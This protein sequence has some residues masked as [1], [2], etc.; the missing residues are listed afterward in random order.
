MFL[1]GIVSY[2]V[3]LCTKLVILKDPTILTVDWVFGRNVVTVIF[4]L[5]PTIKAGGLNMPSATRTDKILVLLSGPV[6][7]LFL[8]GV[9]FAVEH[10]NVSE[11]YIVRNTAPFF[12]ALVGFAALRE[13]LSVADIIGMIIAF[14]GVCLV[15]SSSMETVTS[16]D[17]DDQNP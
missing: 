16:L 2:S 9:F 4:F 15:V 12:I 17:E 7:L 14:T 13:R 8:F 5:W 10:L 6:T 3:G 1:S 11:V